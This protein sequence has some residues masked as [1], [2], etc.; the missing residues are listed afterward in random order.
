[1]SAAAGDA[2]ALFRR[3]LR[4]A[5]VLLTGKAAAGLLNL[6]AT[7]IAV[8]ALGAEAFGTLLLAHALARTAGSIAKFQSWQAVLRY[9][10]PAL[11]EGR[12]E[13]FRA[14]LRFTAGLDAASSV[15]G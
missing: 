8:R 15:A 3:V 7:A 4:N 11:R 2:R 12:R 9:G 14:L 10:A 6:A 1:M 5:G 13:E